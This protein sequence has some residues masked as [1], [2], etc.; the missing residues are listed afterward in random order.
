MA[1]RAVQG[2]EPSKQGDEGSEALRHLHPWQYALFARGTGQ[3]Y[4][5]RRGCKIQMEKNIY[6]PT[7]IFHERSCSST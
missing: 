3:I 6:F 2:Q 4:P 5:L 7:L 1:R